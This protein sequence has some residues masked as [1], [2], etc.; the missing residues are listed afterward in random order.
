MILGNDRRKKA[1]KCDYIAKYYFD[2]RSYVFYTM[3]RKCK[4][5]YRKHN[6]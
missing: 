5:F 1:G 6:F 4:S 2:Y 3:C